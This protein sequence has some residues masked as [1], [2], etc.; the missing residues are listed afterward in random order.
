MLV[1][2]YLFTG[3]HFLFRHGRISCWH[4]LTFW[5]SLHSGS[6]FVCHHPKTL[7]YWSCKLQSP[8]QN[9]TWLQVEDLL[10]FEI[11]TRKTQNSA[12]T[13]SCQRAIS[14]S[15]CPI[16]AQDGVLV[17]HLISWMKGLCGPV[18]KVH[19]LTSNFLEPQYCWGAIYIYIYWHCFWYSRVVS[20][21]LFLLTTLLLTG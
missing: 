17:L 21:K 9:V 20:S 4:C 3:T 8:K 15:L 11:K 13:L 6:T 12:R 7:F 18:R 14:P 2:P 1:D 19:E 5:E 10:S 16:T